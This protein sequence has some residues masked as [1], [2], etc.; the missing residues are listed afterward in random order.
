MEAE[1]NVREFG[2]VGDGTADDTLALRSSLRAAASRGGGVVRIGAG[3]YRTGPLTLESGVELRVDSG[4]VVSFIP[5]FELYE[6]VRSRWEGVEC[7]CM[8]PLLFASGARGIAITGGGTLDGNGAAWWDAYRAIRAS[9][10][11]RPETPIELELARLNPEY[12]SQPSGGGG[13]ETQFLRPPLVQ[14]LN[15][16]DARIEGVRLVNSPC[17]NTHLVYCRNLVVRG[18]LFRNPYDA[19]NTDGLNLDSCADAL[20][21]DCEF[22]VGDDCLGLKSGSGEDGVRVGKPTERVKVR[23]CLMRAGH[24]GVVVGS[25]TAGGVRDVEVSDCRFIGT[26]RGLR[27]KTRRGRGGVVENIALRDCEMEDTLCPVVVNCYYGPG[28]PSADSPLFSLEPQ[29]ATP[30]TP[31]I[32]G[33][34]VERLRATGCRAAAAF[35]VGLPESPIVDLSLLDSSFSLS[36]DSTAVPQDAAMTRGLP[37]PAGRGIRLRNATG[38]RLVGVSVSPSGEKPFLYEGGVDFKEYGA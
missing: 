28:G 4:A 8:Q 34:L 15:C 18:A 2:A 5:D 19:P 13:R 29:P 3:T 10:R 27:I 30:T 33:I 14:F 11:K 22:D 26:D 24:G 17:W 36:S 16:E 1:I 6:P 25:E 38:L 35:A 9:G 7:W 12:E 20:V 21:E 31:M 37:P 32:R 23:R